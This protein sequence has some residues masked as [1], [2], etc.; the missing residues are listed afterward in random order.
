MTTFPLSTTQ[1]AIWFDQLLAP[2]L[3]CYNIGGALRFGPKLLLVGR[4]AEIGDREERVS[5]AGAAFGARHE[6]YVVRI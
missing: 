4:H 1:Q 6:A 2:Q 3:P 5:G